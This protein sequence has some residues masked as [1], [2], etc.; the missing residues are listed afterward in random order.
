MA[1]FGRLTPGGMTLAWTAA[2]EVAAQFDT[3]KLRGVMLNST[4]GA[5]C[6]QH[7]PRERTQALLQACMHWQV[8]AVLHA[9]ASWR[10]ACKLLLCCAH[11]HRGS[12]MQG[13]AW[14][15][16]VPGKTFV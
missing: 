9:D 13:N 5:G 16:V 6:T 1:P 8:H 11:A 3:V 4:C 12:S 15:G 2:V 14:Q 10:H 7:E